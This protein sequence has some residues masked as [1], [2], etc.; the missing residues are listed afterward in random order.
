MG[1]P[2]IEV[3]NEC[4]NPS[5]DSGAAKSEADQDDALDMIS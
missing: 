5:V 1:Q 4:S 2:E 3:S